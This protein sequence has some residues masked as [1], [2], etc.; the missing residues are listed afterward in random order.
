VPGAGDATVLNRTEGDG[1]VRVW[2][3]VVE[4]VDNP[5]VTDKGEAMA[6]EGVGTAFAFFKV[7]GTGD[8]VES[9]KGEVFRAEFSVFRGGERKR[10]KFSVFR[11]VGLMR[12]R[13]VRVTNGKMELLMTVFPT[14]KTEN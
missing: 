8:F 7:F 4:G 5:F 11:G 14:L 3:T 10:G 12:G 6:L 13:R 2:A 9:H 1:G